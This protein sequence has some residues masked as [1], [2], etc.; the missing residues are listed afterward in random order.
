MIEYLGSIEFLIYY[1][2]ETFQQKEFDENAIKRESM[3]ASTQFDENIPT[4]I[5][6]EL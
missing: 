6:G 3:F 5:K 2:Q 4:W 1:T